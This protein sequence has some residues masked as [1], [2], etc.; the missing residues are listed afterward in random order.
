M[1]AWP[2]ARPDKSRA[3]PPSVHGCRSP[4]PGPS[5]PFSI[6]NDHGVDHASVVFPVPRT[7][8]RRRHHGLSG[9][10][11]YGHGP[12]RRARAG[13]Q[14]AHDPGGARRPGHGPRRRQHHQHPCGGAPAHLAHGPVF[15]ERANIHPSACTSTGT[16][17]IFMT[18]CIPHRSVS[19][20]TQ[21]GD[22]ASLTVG[23]RLVM[24]VD[25]L[26]QFRRNKSFIAERREALSL[27]SVLSLLIIHK[28]TVCLC[29]VIRCG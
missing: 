17:R 24:F 11:L 1:P 9:P 2:T 16:K 18:D 23:N 3:S 28:V 26:H 14:P 15:R 4:A 8:P 13:F 21:S 12:C 19:T 22:G 29:M 20:H 10:A 6:R 27:L 5:R 7:A 25:I